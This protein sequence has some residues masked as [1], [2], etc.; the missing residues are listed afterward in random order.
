MRES[1]EPTFRYWDQMTP[2]SVTHRAGL[3]FVAID[4]QEIWI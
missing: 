2:W 1:S 4:R 3:A